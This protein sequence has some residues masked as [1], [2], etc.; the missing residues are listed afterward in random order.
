[1]YLCTGNSGITC[2]KC[3]R[4]YKHKSS[5]HRHLKFECG[6]DPKFQ[7]TFCT[8]KAKQPEHLKSHMALKHSSLI[9]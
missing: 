9:N 2:N 3:G 5:L 7:C 8:Y 1:M 6:V 4:W